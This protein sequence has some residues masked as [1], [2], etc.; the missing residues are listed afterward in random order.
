MAEVSA[1]ILLYRQRPPAPEVLLIHPGG[2]YWRSKDEG[3]WM[4]PKGGVMPGESPA[5]AALREFEEELGMKVDG[6]PIPLCRIRQAGG[7]WVDAFAVEGDFDPANIVSM[8]FNMEWP[9]RSGVFLSFPEAD[10][11]DWFTLPVARA[12]ML[13]SQRPILGALEALLAGLPMPS[14]CK[15]VPDVAPEGGA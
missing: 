2:P 1:G 10:K 3:A 15:E 8:H 12:K 9:P 14:E 7:K 11:A 4:I 5:A 13:P 6:N